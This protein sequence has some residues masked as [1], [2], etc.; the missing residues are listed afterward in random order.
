[1]G[2]L[3]I[4][5]GATA[6]LKLITRIEPTMNVKILSKTDDETEVEVEGE[7][8]TLMNVLKDGLLRLDEVEAATYDMNPEQSGGQTEPIMYIKTD[9]ADP[10]DALQEATEE[11]QEDAAEFREAFEGAI[12]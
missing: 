10:L 7:D 5:N 4:T 2:E 1:M 12:A 3:D 11:I 6:T 9:G 8:H